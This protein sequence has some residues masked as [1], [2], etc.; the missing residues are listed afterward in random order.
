VMTY[1]VVDGPVHC[2]AVRP[3]SLQVVYT[4]QGSDV[5][6]LDLRDLQRHLAGLHLEI[7]GVAEP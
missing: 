3:G 5:Y 1:E 6:R 2:L 4:T 7:P